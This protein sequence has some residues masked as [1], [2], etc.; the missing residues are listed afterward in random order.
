MKPIVPILRSAARRDDASLPFANHRT[1]PVT[2]WSFQPSSPELRGGGEESRA[3]FPAPAFH[4]IS[5]D[6]FAEEAKGYSRI[7][8]AIFALIVGLTAWP[9]ALAAKAGYE[10]LK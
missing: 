7:E 2:A 10:L 6:F 9:L 4:T 5:D 1:A 8:S 3:T